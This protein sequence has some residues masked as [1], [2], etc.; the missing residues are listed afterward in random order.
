MEKKGWL[1]KGGKEERRGRSYDL[2]SWRR[3]KKG[4]EKWEKRVM[5]E[6]KER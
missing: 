6:T 2:A 3:V 1:K 4:N 5:D